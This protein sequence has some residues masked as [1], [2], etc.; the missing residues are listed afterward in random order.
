L[1]SLAFSFLLEENLTIILKYKPKNLG[2]TETG[3][4]V[5]LGDGGSTALIILA[6]LVPS[7]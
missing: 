3:E 1:I 4:N 2:W 7:K 6:S 5:S